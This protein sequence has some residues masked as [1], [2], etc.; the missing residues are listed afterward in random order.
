[1]TIFSRKKMVFLPVFGMMEHLALAVARDC[2][3][4][5]NKAI[6]KLS[7][8][9]FLSRESCEAPPGKAL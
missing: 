1:M 3:S 6:P 7:A 9:N 2:P 4:F 5:L 8:Q